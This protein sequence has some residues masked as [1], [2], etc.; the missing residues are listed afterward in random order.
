[1]PIENLPE[2]VVPFKVEIYRQLVAEFAPYA[3]PAA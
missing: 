1:M 3:T 2:I